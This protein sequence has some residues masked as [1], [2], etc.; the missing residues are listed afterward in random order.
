MDYIQF[1]S[2]IEIALLIL[3][4]GLNI[5]R[6]FL[7]FILQLFDLFRKITWSVH[8]INFTENIG[9]P[10]VDIPQMFRIISPTLS[11][12]REYF[13]LIIENPYILRANEQWHIVKDS[14][15]NSGKWHIALVIEVVNNDNEIVL[16]LDIFV[17]ASLF[18][19]FP[20]EAAKR[21]LIDVAE[22][23]ENTVILAEDM[24]YN[25]RV[26]GLHDLPDYPVIIKTHWVRIIQ[27]LWR[28]VYYRRLKL[29]GSLKAQR[30][31]ELSGKYGIGCGCGLRGMLGCLS[32]ASEMPSSF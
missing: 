18:Y 24:Q 16:C 32:C 25:I 1:L 23:D 11:Q 26:N 13:F 17:D 10:S 30:Q 12:T 9:V 29:R 6:T 27:R 15:P 14:S 22:E 19:K 28:K 21:Y 4:T 5:R 31:F 20:M 2:N 3:F 8:P 7:M